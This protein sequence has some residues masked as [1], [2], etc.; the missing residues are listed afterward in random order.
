[1]H[2][3]NY[4]PLPLGSL[5][6][7]LTD[8]QSLNSTNNIPPKATILLQCLQSWEIKN[9]YCPTPVYELVK[10]FIILF[11]KWGGVRAP[12]GKVG[13]E[14]IGLIFPGEDRGYMPRG[15]WI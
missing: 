2:Q 12:G 11:W 9:I 10:G 5:T 7:I 8:V 6:D 14:R 15:G 13:R 1:M 4:S 3:L